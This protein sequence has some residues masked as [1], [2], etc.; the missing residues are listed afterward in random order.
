MS[1]DLPPW[2]TTPGWEHPPEPKEAC[3]SCG[4]RISV[5]ANGKL[6]PHGPRGS[7]RT[8]FTTDRP[9]HSVRAKPKPT[10]EGAA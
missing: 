1:A 3:P 4:K 2:Q 5:M 9:C 7:W 10:G 8:G 6:R